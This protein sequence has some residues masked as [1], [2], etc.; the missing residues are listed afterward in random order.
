MPSKAKLVFIGVSTGGSSIRRVFP[1]WS[2]M[3]GLNCEIMGIDLPLR[4][5]AE[6]YRRALT[7]IIADPAVKG[8]LITAHKIDLLRACRDMF[9]QLDDYAQI[10]DEVSCIIK[11]A[12]QVQGYAVDPLSSVDALAQFVPRDHWCGQRDVLCL[13]AGGAAIAISV[14]LAQ[15]GANGQPR[16]VI[17]ADILPERLESIQ[18]IH[19]KLDTPIQFDYHLSR[20]PADNDALLA[21]L[22]PG[23]LVIN[24]TGL[25]KD[26][27]GSPLSPAAR[28]P[29]DGLIWELNYRGARDFMRQA[30]EQADAL[31]LTIE[32][33]WRY[34]V[35]GWTRVIAEVFN[36][37]ID[38]AT[39]A[40]LADAASGFRV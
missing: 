37:E 29:Q 15:S 38:G 34:F 13:G 12:G 30:T 20:T 11:R 40:R 26:R 16:R 9:D 6:R 2:E 10:C 32:D 27:P 24:A 19:A 5:P 8:A 36:I 23:S 7:D 21:D 39:F 18:R 17:L 22:P 31:N 28:F 4:A 1:R 25:G 14:A 35:H 33:G 3:L